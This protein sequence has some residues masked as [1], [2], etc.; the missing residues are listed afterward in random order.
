MALMHYC[1][2]PFD[3]DIEGSQGAL[4]IQ[5]KLTDQEGYQYIEVSRSI[6]LNRPEKTFPVTGCTASIQDELGNVFIAEELQPGQYASWIPAEYLTFGT[7]YQLIVGTPDGR[8]YISEYEELLDCPP[9]DSIIWEKKPLPTT[10]PDLT[11]NGVQF[12]VSTDASGGYAK[13]FRWELEETWEYHSYSEI[14][15]FYNGGDDVYDIVVPKAD[16]T[17]IYSGWKEDTLYYCWN[18]RIVPEIYTY[19]TQNLNSGLVKKF[20]LHHVSNKTDRL[21][22]RYHLIVRQYSLTT[23]AHKYWEILEDQSKQ[24]GRLYETQPAR[25]TGNIHSVDDPDESVLGLFYATSVQE[26]S[27]FIS[28]GLPPFTHICYLA[29]YTPQELMDRLTLNTQAWE[30]PI[31]LFIVDTLQD[32]YLFDYAPQEC[33][34]CTDKGGTIERPDWWQ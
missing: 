30:Y 2:F 6:L 13:N 28:P 8:N 22:Y 20:P 33:F 18:S 29:G 7:R 16:T 11:Y 21:T 25:I 10:D 27:I 4:V 26:K 9:I 17:Q 3:P 24:S 14:N 23:T 32:W 19:S 12:Y 34:D 31:W 1:V 15:A 5:G